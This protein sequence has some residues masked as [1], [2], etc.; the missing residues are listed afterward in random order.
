[1]GP[2]K[3]MNEDNQQLTYFKNRVAKEQRNAKA[4]EESLT[5]V[6]QK[7]HVT[8]E[9]N[10]LVR[11]RTKEQHEQN[12][13]EVFYSSITSCCAGVVGLFLSSVP[14]KIPENS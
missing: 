2:M 10:R 3:Q 11:Q 6:S 14:I 5:I 7:L 1:M 9:E 8:M 12:K 13:K 4:L